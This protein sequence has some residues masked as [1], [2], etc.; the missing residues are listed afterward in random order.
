MTFSDLL[1]TS[2]FIVT[3]DVIPPKGV[4]ISRMLDRVRYLVGKVDAIN[5]VDLPSAIMRV[6][7]LPVAVILKQQG[8][9]PILQMTCRDRNRLALQADL[10]GAYILG[11]RNVLALTGDNVDLSDNPRVKSVFDLD[12]IGLLRAIR[13]LEK[14]YDLG[15]NSLKGSPRF[16][17]GAVVDLTADP[18][19]P[20][21]ERM[22]QKIE[23]GAEFF[24]TQPIFEI[25]RIVKFIEKAGKIKTPILGGVL[26]LKSSKMA[27]FMDK[28]VPGIRIPKSIIYQIEKAKNPVE[29]S[30]QI[31][32]N[33]INQLKEICRGIHIMTVNWE[34]KI[35]LLLQKAHL[36]HSI[37]KTSS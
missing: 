18:L 29:A 14:G 32:C 36:P 23:A 28:N 5:V 24:Q 11:I 1:N 9:E 17:K 13:S 7:S 33:I 12:S 22:H 35:P 3:T 25:E 37:K 19:E 34:D 10:L 21:I 15:N 27:Y 26:L 8:L 2:K 4:N 16:C 6:S 31:A 20:E 30:I